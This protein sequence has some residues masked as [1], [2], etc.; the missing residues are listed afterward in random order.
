MT[1]DS[2][3][4]VV[5]KRLCGMGKADGSPLSPHF[6]MTFT[7]VEQYRLL[8]LRVPTG[9][10]VYAIRSPGRQS[11]T[12]QT[13]CRTLVSSNRPPS[14]SR[15]LRVS[16]PNRFLRHVTLLSDKINFVIGLC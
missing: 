14:P 1:V 11:R 13:L 4:R 8:A 7:L 3:P 10:A 12:P 5:S 16:R 6:A 9:D 15:V 2:S